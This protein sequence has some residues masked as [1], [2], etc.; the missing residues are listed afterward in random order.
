[1]LMGKLCQR[2]SRGSRETPGEKRLMNELG[3]GNQVPRLSG[4]QALR[5]PGSQAVLAKWSKA[6]LLSLVAG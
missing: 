2:V 4:S 6:F 3:L 1:M 5:L